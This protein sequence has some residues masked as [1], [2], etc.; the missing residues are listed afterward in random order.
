[1]VMRPQL[2]GGTGPEPSIEQEPT[3]LTNLFRHDRIVVLASLLVVILSAWAYLLAGAGMD[4]RAMGGMLMPIASQDWTL[5]HFILML[6][7]WVVMMLAMML[8]SA[9]PMILF[10]DKIASNRGNANQVTGSTSFFGLGYMV[11]WAAFSVR[12]SSSSTDWIERSCFRQRWKHTV[13]P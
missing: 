3:R 4:M 8:P 7:M 2:D 1:M 12:L 13:L 5:G 9:A 10:Y 6:A 11:V